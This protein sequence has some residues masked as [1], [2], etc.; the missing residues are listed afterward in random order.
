M[1]GERLSRYRVVTTLAPG[2]ERV[3]LL[4][5]RGTG[6]PCRL[7]TRYT[8]TMLRP[9][10]LAASSIAAG[11]RALR[12][13]YEWSSL[14]LGRSLDDVLT[15]GD[16]L[17]AQQI[18]SLAK[19]MKQGER[20]LIAGSVGTDAGRS[21]VDYNRRWGLVGNFFEWRADW[22]AL[23]ERRQRGRQQDIARAKDA[24]ARLF[25]QHRHKQ[26]PQRLIQP[27]NDEEW[28]AVQGAIALDRTDVW[29]DVRVRVRNHTMVYTVAGTGIRSAE[30]L[31]LRLIDLPHGRTR[32]IAIV[33]NPD[34][35]DDPRRETPEV[36]TLGRLLPIGEPLAQ[37]LDRY[38]TESRHPSRSKYLF[39]GQGGDPLTPRTMRQIMEHLS[40]VT[41]YPLHWHR[42]RHMYLNRVERDLKDIQNGQ[43]LL[44]EVAG[45][46]SETSAQPYLKLQRQR[47]AQE[48]LRGYHDGLYPPST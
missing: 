46:R 10:G 23:D 7:A 40:R 37:M 2:G 48:I 32:A 42:L 43:T 27:L 11:L 15:A 13:A 44:K 33:R 38:T 1:A 36:K 39:V 22:Y 34:D 24:V 26:R 9:R 19:Y 4:V 29:P 28:A 6:I 8:V 16:E 25:G 14:V 5:E 31:K 12:D 35:P 18:A 17:T 41:G 21:S 47:D 30:L 3:P 45:W 20:G